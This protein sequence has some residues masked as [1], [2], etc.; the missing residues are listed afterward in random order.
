MIIKSLHF[1]VPD[2]VTPEEY[3][4]QYYKLMPFDNTLIFS[5]FT[6]DELLALDLIHKKNENSQTDN[7]EKRLASWCKSSASGDWKLFEKRLAKDGLKSKDV[8]SKFSYV[9]SS[10]SEWNMPD[11]A[12]DVQW[13]FNAITESQASKADINLDKTKPIAFQEIILPILPKAILEVQKHIPLNALQCFTTDA[14]NDLYITLLNQLSDLIAPLLYKHFVEHLKKL[15]PN[16]N[17]LPSDVDKEKNH[18]CNFIDILK[19]GYLERLLHEKPV[20]LRLIATTTRQWISTTSQLINRTSADINSISEILFHAENPLKV[21]SISESQSDLHNLGESV[22]ILS[23]DDGNKV[24]Y[25]PKDLR[26]D[27]ILF[28]FINFLNKKDPPY[29]LRLPRVISCEGYGWA[30]FIEHNSCESSQDFKLFYERSGAWLILLHLLVCVDMHYENIIA[31]GSHPVPID[32]ETILQASNPELEFN[33]EALA[34]NN[35]AIDKIQNS[36]LLV[37]MLPSYIKL[38]QNIVNDMGGLN[39]VRRASLRG[40]WRNIN[41]NGMRWIQQQSNIEISPN[42]PHLN[43]KY[44]QFGDFK[45]EFLE[46]FKQ[47]AHF[48]QGQ[49]DSAYLKDLWRS[50]SNLQ[51]RKVVRPTRFYFSLLQRLKDHRAMDDGITWS[52]QADFLARFA[53]LDGQND[54]LWPLQKAE[55]E[56]LFHLNIPYFLNSTNSNDL[57]DK[58]A[59]SIST[60]A[61]PGLKRALERWENLT[62]QE[63][64]WQSRIIEISTNFVR[65]SKASENQLDGINRPGRILAVNTRKESSDNNLVKELGHIIDRIDYFSFQDRNSI[66]WIGLDWITDSEVGILAPLGPDLYGGISGIAVFLAAYHRQ[67]NTDRSQQMLQKILNGL[68]QYTHHSGTARWSRTLGIGGANG[69]GS[70][71]YAQTVIAS[72]LN[73]QSILEDAIQTSNIL[74]KELIDTD[75]NLDVIS[76]SAGAILCLLALYRNTKSQAVLEKAILCGEHLLNTPRVGKAGFRSW[77]GMGMSDIPLNGMAHGAAG[78]QYALTSLAI[79]STRQDFAD[80]A[81]ECLAYEESNYDAS[82]FN[83]PDLSMGNGSE[84][85]MKNI[86]CQWCHGAL[87]IG[88]SR[89]GQVKRGQELYLT[90]AAIKNACTGA[91][92]NW[93][94]AFDNLCCGTLGNI[95]LLN[96]ASRL[97][98]DPKL[99]ELSLSRLDA[100]MLTREKNRGYAFSPKGDEFNLGFF[101]GLSGVGYTLL[102]TL[103]P[104]LPNILL[105]E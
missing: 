105:W 34:A 29:N 93:P 60:R 83:W 85:P 19:T 23:F 89:I 72:I 46:G 71:L 35:F 82:L 61:K 96:E 47:Y 68:R 36:V 4:M 45:S 20:L 101:R 30:E 26:L 37:G 7:A 48:L 69:I 53:D 76:G 16:G 73:D 80:A 77:V 1:M 88:M 24:V 58:F 13:I 104:N 65:G 9:F 97:L 81:K 44:A 67:F 56:A 84:K 10:D 38:P 11:W 2:K 103:N 21:S 3:F 102:R 25:K 91:I 62:N 59:N 28:K 33:Q 51:T 100:V 14:K 54:F 64:L 79:A 8:L 50:F 90:E 98:N 41:T 70:I 40:E 87:G 31:S 22:R 66:S 18:Y 63:I 15:D 49:K 78:F 43:S 86:L 74:T 32:L 92:K 12:G 55:R 5:A 95:E 17:L 99:Q 42:I 39:A 27:E 57:S 75:K 52:V 6:F 94:N